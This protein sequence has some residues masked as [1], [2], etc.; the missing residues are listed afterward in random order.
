M[1]LS[2]ETVGSELLKSDSVYC[3]AASARNLLHP[4]VTLG[5]TS[6]Q[7]TQPYYLN[8]LSLVHYRGALSI[9]RQGQTK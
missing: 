2:R 3:A 1:G 9:E 4:N 7:Q 8:D 5:S 6:L